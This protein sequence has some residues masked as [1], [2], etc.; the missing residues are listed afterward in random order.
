[1]IDDTW[2]G[3]AADRS[4]QQQPLS[5]STKHLSETGYNNITKVSSA[6]YKYQSRLIKKYSGSGGKFRSCDDCCGRKNC[7]NDIWLLSLNF[8]SE[9]L[10]IFHQMLNNLH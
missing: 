4:S 2:P 1:M 10:L 8:E 3:M 5:Q 9:K 7:K 6:N